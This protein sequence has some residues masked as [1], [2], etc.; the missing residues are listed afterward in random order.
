MTLIMLH[1]SL[2]KKKRKKSLIDTD[3]DTTE[4]LSHS[5]G[6]KGEDF[7]ISNTYSTYLYTVHALFYFMMF[8]KQ[9]FTENPTSSLPRPSILGKLNNQLISS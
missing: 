6:K 7:Q 9:M 8:I 3:A 4:I 2:K 5:L 1:Y